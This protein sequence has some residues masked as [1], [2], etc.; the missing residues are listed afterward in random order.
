MT[1]ANL[2]KRPRSIRMFYVLCKLFIQHNGERK[3]MV[4]QHVNSENSET[5]DEKTVEY[6]DVAVRTVSTD[7]VFSQSESK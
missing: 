1:C 7:I 5:N 3:G 2:G 6:S 4:C